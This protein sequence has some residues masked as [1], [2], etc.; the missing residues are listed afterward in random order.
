MSKGLFHKA[1]AQSGC[2]VNP[3]TQGTP[4]VK[5]IAKDVKLESS[6]E[7]SV[8]KLLMDKSV[9]ELYEIQN[10]TKDVSLSET[11]ISLD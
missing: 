1:I 11:V 9:E 8:L 7:K 10:K 4:G 2:A 3:W 5:R 6:D